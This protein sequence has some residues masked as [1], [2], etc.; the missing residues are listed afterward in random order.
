MPAAGKKKY[1]QMSGSDYNWFFFLILNE[2]TEQHST[3]IDAI[4]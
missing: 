3:E 2:M 4:S 1:F